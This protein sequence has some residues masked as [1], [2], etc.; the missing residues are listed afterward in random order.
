MKTNNKRRVS[1]FTLLLT[2]LAL[3]GCNNPG[4]PTEANPTETPTEAPTETPSVTG[5]VK[6]TEE[7]HIVYPVSTVVDLAGLYTEETSPEFYVK[8]IIKS[9]SNYGYGEL[10]L[11]DEND[12]NVTLKVFGVR[13]E[14]GYTYYNKLEYVPIVGDTITIVGKVHTYNKEAE[15]GFSGSPARLVAVEKTHPEVDVT[16]YEAHTIA[17]T[18]ALEKGAKVKLTGVVAQTTMTQKYNPN[19]FFLVD[20]TGSTFVFGYEVG[21]TVSVGNT[22][23]VI[24]EVD[25]FVSSSEEALAEKNGYE[26]AFQIT[27]SAIVTNDFGTTD[28]DKSWIKDTT[29]KDILSVSVTEKNITSEIYHVNAVIRKAE[30]SGFVNY[31]INDL[32]RETGTYVYTANNGN[33]YAWLD[34]YCDSVVDLYVSPINCKSTASGCVYRFVPIQIE[35]IE[36]FTFDAEKVPGFVLDYH[37]MKQFT[38]SYAGDPEKELID[39]VSDEFLNFLDAT[40]T[41]SSSNTDLLYF[42]DVDGKQVMHVNPVSGVTASITATCT[43]QGHT[44]TRT[45]NNIFYDDVVAGSISVDEAIEKE[46]GEEIKVIGIVGAALIIKKGFYLMSENN[47]I[48]CQILADSLAAS[49]VNTGDKIVLTGTKNH[50][51]KDSTTKV[52]NLN[53]KD[54]VING[55]VSTGNELPSAQ[56]T[57]KTVAEIYKFSALEDYSTKLFSASVY[58]TKTSGNNP[59]VYFYDSLEAKEANG[60]SIS[61]YLS[62]INSVA[63]LEPYYDKQVTITF[64]LVN[65]NNKTFWKVCP[66]S[67]S[68]GTNSAFNEFHS[69]Q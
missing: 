49:D 30:G 69:I 55:V 3:V 48:A 65:W 62:S 54:C 68:D 5:P 39:K 23:T 20:N 11:Q 10:V 63:F 53:L 15:F 13:G 8:G 7:E 56:V 41:Y 40:V 18:R 64:A 12:S 21:G 14:D 42:E 16:G 46:D 9:V 32:D 28:F 36:N 60:S 2:S 59:Q 26:G 51:T 24:G 47:V 57:D 44:E 19:G 34:S 50:A 4:I 29:I 38:A 22:V 61:I 35:T 43:Y 67:V 37:I 52:G 25:Y 31:Y 66:F 58:L 6:D 27:N 45:I 33:D 1:L 17:E